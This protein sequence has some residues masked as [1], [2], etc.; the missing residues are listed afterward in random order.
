[1]SGTL[2]Y[3]DKDGNVLKRVPISGSI[4]LERLGMSVEEAQQIIDTQQQE[5]TRAHNRE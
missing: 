5:A 1:M 2:E 3:R 4:P